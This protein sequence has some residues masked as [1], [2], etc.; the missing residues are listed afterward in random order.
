LVLF[1]PTTPGMYTFYYG[2]PGHR[3]LGMHGMLVVE[4]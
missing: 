1:T 4:Q 3:E 2:V